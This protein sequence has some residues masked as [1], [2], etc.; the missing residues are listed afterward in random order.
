[1]KKRYFLFLLFL[2]VLGIC[3]VNA[4]SYL[5]LYM[6]A[7]DHGLC[8][9]TKQSASKGS[10]RIHYHTNGGTNLYYY[11]KSKGTSLTQTD[12]NFDQDDSLYKASATTYSR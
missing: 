5:Q 3:K 4:V 2:L 1:M 7:W 8:E 6:S 9:G 11:E 12:F 10:G